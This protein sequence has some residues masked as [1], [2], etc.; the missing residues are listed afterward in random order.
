[1][2]PK[3]KLR[4]ED[5]YELYVIQKLST[6]EIAPILN[7]SKSAV[8]S[9]VRKHGFSR[10]KDEITVRDNF[11]R[12]IKPGQ[13]LP[14]RDQFEEK[15]PRWKGGISEGYYTRI[16]RSNKDDICEKCGS[17][18]TIEVH[19]IDR[20]RKNNKIEN[21]LLLCKS[22]HSKEHKVILHIK[23]MRLKYEKVKSGTKQLKFFES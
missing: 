13:T 23:R 6:R 2:P 5:L 22:C 19:H 16:S 21:L 8:S 7:S 10:T 11:G 3:S 1:M 15:N 17:S 18:E 4:K 14:Q 20:N 9:Q 12:F